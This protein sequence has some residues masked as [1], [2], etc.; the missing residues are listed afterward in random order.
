MRA[1]VPL[2]TCNSTVMLVP[3]DIVL[4]PLHVT[5]NLTILTIPFIQIKAT[6]AVDI[7]L[8]TTR[9]FIQTTQLTT[10]VELMESGPLFITDTAGDIFRS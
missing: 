8:T 3:V 9:L 2:A 5:N 10:S 1:A 6:G 7:I 4:H